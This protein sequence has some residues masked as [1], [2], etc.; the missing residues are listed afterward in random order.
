VDWAL[1]QTVSIYS[2]GKNSIVLY[3]QT[4]KYSSVLDEGHCKMLTRSRIRELT[5]TSAAVAAETLKTIDMHDPHLHRKGM[6]A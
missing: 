6:W 4:D 2:K 3:L 1:G 5:T